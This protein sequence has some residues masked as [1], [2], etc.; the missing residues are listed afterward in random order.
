MERVNGSTADVILSFLG[1]LDHEPD[2][3]FPDLDAEAFTDENFADAP[4]VS[5]TNAGFSQMEMG[6]KFQMQPQFGSVSYES[7]N[8]DGSEDSYDDNFFVTPNTQFNNIFENQSPISSYTSPETSA[9][10][11][12]SSDSESSPVPAKTLRQTQQATKSVSKLKKKKKIKMTVAEKVTTLV[13][14]LKGIRKASQPVSPVSETLSDSNLSLD[15]AYQ[16][17]ELFLA[18]MLSGDLSRPE[19]LTNTFEPF[20]SLYIPALTSLFSLA[21]Q[22][23]AE[24]KLSAWA[25]VE[26]SETFPDKHSGAGQVA[27]ASRCFSR[28]L[29]DLLPGSGARSSM[30]NVEVKR[31]AISFRNQLIAPFTWRCLSRDGSHK[32]VEFSGLIRCNFAQSKISFAHISFDAFTVIRQCT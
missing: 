8:P 6:M 31:S 7:S 18:G 32:K 28:V 25:P 5:M 4:T 1:D 10:E 19:D 21:H 30:I 20:G 22:R 24:S 2:F 3:F 23:R 16:R 29:S 14:I 26:K 13:T 27:A 9:S 17:A 15:E 12:S 11:D